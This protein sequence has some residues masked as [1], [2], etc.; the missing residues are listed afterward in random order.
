MWYRVSSMGR[1]SMGRDTASLQQRFLRYVDKTSSPKGC[2]L[3]TGAKDRDGYGSFK[4]R[5]DGKLEQRAHRI[6]YIWWKAPIPDGSWM[7]HKV[8]CSDSSC[9]NPDHV[10]AGNARQNSNDAITTGAM[11]RGEASSH[12]KLT[13][14]QVRVI[15]ALYR[16]G[17]GTQASLALEFGVVPFAIFQIIKRRTW[18]HVK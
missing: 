7:L 8:E 11:R 6:A 17:Q 10:Y 9:C 16:R 2:W 1:P 14:L 5:V 13:A 3:W 18:K 4:I 15:R 12:S